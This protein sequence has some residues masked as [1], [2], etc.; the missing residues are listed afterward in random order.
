[1]VTLVTSLVVAFMS[2]ATIGYVYVEILET[3]KGD[4]S[5][6]GE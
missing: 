6:L 1:M 5:G 4:L 3:A 2:L